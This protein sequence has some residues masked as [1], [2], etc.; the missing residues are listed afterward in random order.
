MKL[1]NN[2]L[3]ACKLFSIVL[4]FACT[5][6]NNKI[7]DQYSS[8]TGQIVLSINNLGSRTVLPESI[9]ATIAKYKIYAIG[10]DNIKS[11]TTITVSNH[12]ISELTPGM[13][14]ITIEGL[15][16]NDNL[17][18]RGIKS[19]I[20]VNKNEKVNISVSLLPIQN[21]KGSLS[22]TIDWSNTT[23]TDN[24]ISDISVELVSRTTN[25]SIPISH[26]HIGKSITINKELDSDF[27]T[28]SVALKKG[29]ILYASILEIIQVYDYLTSS[30]AI[31]LNDS[32]VSKPPLSPTN[33]KVEQTDNTSIKISWNDNSKTELFYDIYVNKNN[34]GFIELIKNL[35]A[36]TNT[37]THENLQVGNK[38]K[39]KVVA[40]NS[41]GESD[42]L[43]GTAITT[44]DITSTNS[45]ISID[46]SYDESQV[47]DLKLDS[48]TTFEL[49]SSFKEIHWWL[50]MTIYLGYKGNDT[51]YTFNPKGN[52]L[53]TGSHEL[54]IRYQIA[55]QPKIKIIKINIIQ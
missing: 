13:W 45:K 42:P 32:D 39:Y 16:E 3:K 4:L 28:I 14:S 25:Q 37:Y 10:P 21:S 43:T 26:Q 36:N 30:K 49:D 53:N 2:I 52:G 22:F 48:D 44:K 15:N 24:T 8:N 23:M 40:K 18:A 47:I 6:Q 35:P 46:D 17:V 20:E 19:D 7:P 33:Y 41:F 31:T 50:N 5:I 11:E 55:Y 1:I 51:A 29:N 34:S 9:T 12:I 27:Y 54:T 38:Y